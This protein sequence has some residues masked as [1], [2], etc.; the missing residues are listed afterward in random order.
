MIKWR[1]R[2]AALLGLTLVTACGAQ[3][4]LEPLT[5]SVAL[6]EFDSRVLE[7]RYTDADGYPVQDARCTFSTVGNTN[8]AYL[9]SRVSTTDR[10]G[11]CRTTLITRNAASFQVIVEADG[12]ASAR[13]RAGVGAS[14]TR[15]Q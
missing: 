6:L 9:Q 4:I 10:D 12:A 8:G 3:G 13:V 5:P 14:G 15:P 7:V 11:I 1:I 2:E